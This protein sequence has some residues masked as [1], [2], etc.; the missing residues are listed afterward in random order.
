MRPMNT[1]NPKA[2]T[3][4]QMSSSLMKTLHN[5]ISKFASML[6]VI[7]VAF[8]VMSFDQGDSAGTF[9]TNYAGRK[10]KAE[11]V[12]AIPDSCCVVGKEIIPVV[13]KV[14]LRMPDRKSLVNADYET[15]RHFIVSVK[16]ALVRQMWAVP[17][18]ETIKTSD[19][20]INANFEENH[21]TEVMIPSNSDLAKA[22]EDMDIEFARSQA[23]H[24]SN[25]S[26]KY[27]AVAD[28]EMTENFAIENFKMSNPS[29]DQVAKADQDMNADFEATN[30]PRISMPAAALIASADQG[31]SDFTHTAKKV[32]TGKSVKGSVATNK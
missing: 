9:D 1:V 23:S 30:N 6:L 10:D 21:G 18:V 5:S 25:P 15:M 31:M 7:A 24:L 19:D 27:V 32:R 12:K 29:N 22:D 17:A 16:E 20:A 28:E 2:G 13:K 26:I 11:V 8:S 14:S 3:L 4:K